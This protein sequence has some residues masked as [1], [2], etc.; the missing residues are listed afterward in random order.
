M[1]IKL[2]E[3]LA[4]FV[5]LVSC[6]AIYLVA[7]PAALAAVTGVGSA[8]FATWRGTRPDRKKR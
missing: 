4:L 3:L 8:L 6:G 7:G 5:I 2:V 1:N